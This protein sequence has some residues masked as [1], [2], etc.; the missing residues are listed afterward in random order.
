MAC[1]FIWYEIRWIVRIMCWRVLLPQP[2][3]CLYEFLECLNVQQSSLLLFCFT[4]NHYLHY[5][6]ALA[7]NSVNLIKQSCCIQLILMHL[8]QNIIKMSFS[9]FS[10][11]SVWAQPSSNWEA[12]STKS[13]Y[14][15][16]TP[17]MP[18]IQPFC[19]FEFLA[20]GVKFFIVLYVESFGH[21]F[22]HHAFCQL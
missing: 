13:R 1:R 2:F 10:W 9:L 22:F 8:L 17:L 7:S 15:M 16:C 14:L 18:K 20:D 4:L 19:G 3:S 12:I 11:S 6:L 21:C 5:S